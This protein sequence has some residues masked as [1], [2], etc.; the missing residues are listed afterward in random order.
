M[1]FRVNNIS[2]LPVAVMLHG[3][4]L[5][6]WS[7]RKAVELLQGEYQ[8][9]T[10]IIDGHG[11]DAES[12]FIS[13]EDCAD[14][15][16]SNI[17]KHF[18]GSVELLTGLS[19]GA[20]I[21]IEALMRR[22]A[23]AKNAVIESGLILPM[24]S[25]AQMVPSSMKMSYPLIK[26]KWFAKLQ[27]KSLFIEQDMFER[28][29]QD[30]MKM[31][32]DSLINMSVSNALYDPQHLKNITSKTLILIGEKEISAMKK[33]AEKLNDGIVDSRMVTLTS[34]GHGQ[35]SLQNPKQYVELVKQ[36][37]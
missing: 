36:Y 20:Q 7:L 35:V 18:G 26:Q 31:S 19:I 29:Y 23:L 12:T 33:S 8:V 24:K 27:A 37:L 30:S 9:I 28:Y 15:L 6:D 25:V 16:I 21:V 34:M 5:S 4:G 10:P 2:N 17:D 14:K 11:E 32:L 3:G 1:I 22:P 13:I